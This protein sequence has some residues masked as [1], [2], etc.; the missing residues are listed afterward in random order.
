[1]GSVW[2]KYEKPNS[3]VLA[4]LQELETYVACVVIDDKET[5]TETL[6]GSDCVTHFIEPIHA[7]LVVVQPRSDDAMKESSSRTL[8]VSQL[9]L[10]LPFAPLKMIAGWTEV[11][12][13]L[14]PL[15]SGREH[16]PFRWLKNCV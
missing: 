4:S 7:E 13:E 15:R 11:P 1:M 2:R 12:C 8:P 3:K 16:A 9:L 5:A 14:C 6:T 10:M